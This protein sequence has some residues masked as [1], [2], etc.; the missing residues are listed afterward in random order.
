M[1]NNS[2]IILE[3]IWIALGVV[4]IT[5][6]IRSAITNGGSKVSLFA[7]M[8]FVCFIFAWVRDRQRKKG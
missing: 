3:I 1:R 2:Q 5:A 6:A 8:A 4:C 7:L